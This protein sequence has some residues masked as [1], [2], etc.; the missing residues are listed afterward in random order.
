MSVVDIRARGVRLFPHSAALAPQFAQRPVLS[1]D[2]FA[3]VRLKL[4][5]DE[6]HDSLV[7]WRQAEEFH[8]ASS[9]LSPLASPLTS[10]YCIL[11]ATKTLLTVRKALHGASHGLSGIHSSGGVSLTR[12][13]VSAASGGVFPAL[14]KLCGGGANP[15]DKFS[16]KELL[17]ELPFVHRSFTLTYPNVRELFIPLEQARFVKKDNGSEAWFCARIPPSY[18][19]Q[20]GL[21]LPTG[22]EADPN[23]TPHGIRCARRFSWEDLKLEDS[24][25]RLRT[26]H[27][28]LRKEIVPIMTT[29]NRRWYLRRAELRTRSFQLPLLARVFAAMH[30]LSELSRYHPVRLERHLNSKHNWLLTEFMAQA[31]AQFVHL[32]A[33][34]LCGREFISPDS[35]RLP[36]R[37]TSSR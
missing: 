10:Y 9:M 12:E 27:E 24:L 26:Y 29:Q 8:E 35:V 18:A 36:V 15:S 3:Y 30:R 5:R 31:P 23:D 32:I 6:Q 7:Y 16:L 13:T 37:G 19:A 2:P 14:V 1:P 17:A 11:N 33:S 4:A 25:A 21:V 22:F 34:E 20:G 28:R